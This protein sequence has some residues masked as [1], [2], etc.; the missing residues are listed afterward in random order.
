MTVVQVTPPSVEL[1]I[2]Y[3]V[4]AVPPLLAGAVH[5]SEVCES[6]AIA[7]RPWGAVAVAN[8]VAETTDDAP[9]I[10]VMRMP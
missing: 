10:G 6:P 5:D 8:R 9:P 3:P 1:S 4:T 2:R 7:V